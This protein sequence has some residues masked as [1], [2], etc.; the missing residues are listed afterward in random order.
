M[1]AMMRTRYNRLCSRQSRG[2]QWQSMDDKT[3]RL[4]CWSC[5]AAAQQLV[6]QPPWPWSHYCVSNLLG[7]LKT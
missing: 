7:Y 4:A 5:G 1:H 3:Q 2:R 6:L